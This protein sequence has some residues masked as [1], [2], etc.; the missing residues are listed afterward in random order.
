M[1]VKQSNLDENFVGTYHIDVIASY[2]GWNDNLIETKSFF[3]L[4]ILPSN[5]LPDLDSSS[6]EKDKKTETS[7]LPDNQNSE[8][9]LNPD[10]A[11]NFIIAEL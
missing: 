3:L 4:H 8:P 1:S 10:D 9:E 6:D 2:Y 7:D 11:G 5:T